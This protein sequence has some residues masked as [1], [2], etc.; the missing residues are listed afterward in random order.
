MLVPTFERPLT[1]LLAVSS[2]QDSLPLASGKALIPSHPHTLCNDNN[3]YLLS[4][5]SSAALIGRCTDLTTSGSQ[6]AL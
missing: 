3:R 2:A 1:R 4:N 5:I 6:T